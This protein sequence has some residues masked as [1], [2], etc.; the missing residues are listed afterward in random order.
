MAA[1]KIGFVVTRYQT[2]TPQTI[3]D[4]TYS[5]R[6]GRHSRVF[7]VCGVSDYRTY[8][9]RERASAVYSI[10]HAPLNRPKD[11][12]DK[13]ASLAMYRCTYLYAVIH[14]E[15]NVVAFPSIHFAEASPQPSVEKLTRLRVVPGGVGCGGPRR[16]RRILLLLLS[17]L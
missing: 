7:I 10:R 6:F 15:Y 9:R 2:H 13:L 1:G 8:A 12:L 11:P 14:D 4:A 3:A 5:V 17:S 16:R